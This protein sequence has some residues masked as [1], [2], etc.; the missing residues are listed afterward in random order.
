MRHP[1]LQQ[2]RYTRTH[3]CG[4]VLTVPKGPGAEAPEP[5]GIIK[6]RGPLIYSGFG[7]MRASGEAGALW[8]KA[9][10]LARRNG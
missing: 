10:G 8:A 6:G 4:T 3:L 1:A 2:K 5:P 9:Y 7:D